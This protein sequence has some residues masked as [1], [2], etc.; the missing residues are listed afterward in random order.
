MYPRQFYPISARADSVG[1]FFSAPLPIYNRNQGEVERARQEDKQIQA[2]IHALEASITNDVE[3]AYQQYTTT[4]GMVESIE[5]TMLSEARDVRQITEYSY[6][7][8]EAS[9]LEFL[10]AARA[11]NDTMQSFNDARADYARS[12]YLTDF[13]SGK[14]VTP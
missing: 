12:L 9:L 14:G 5:K 2:R 3:T 6:R 11:F 10:D 1:L 4:R 13:V 8:G 7:R